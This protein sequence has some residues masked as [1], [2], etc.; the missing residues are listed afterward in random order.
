MK[1]AERRTKWVGRTS[2]RPRGRRPLVHGLLAALLMMCIVSLIGALVPSGT[3]AAGAIG[4]QDQSW[5]GT[6]TPTGTKRSE[7][8]LWWNDGLWWANMWSTGSRQFHIFRF[9]QATQS[10]SDTGVV[11]DRRSYTHADV[12][13]DGTHLYVASHQYVGESQPA[14]AGYPSYLYRFSYNAATKTYSL[15]SGFP[16]LINNLKTETLVIDKDS[17][18]TLWATWQQDNRIYVT[19]SV[20]GDTTWATPFALPSAGSNVTVD[21]NSAVIAF[22]GNKIGIM[23]SNQTTQADGMYFAVHV[24]GQP[25]TSWEPSRTAI[26]GAGTADDH[27]NLKTDGSGRVYAA[28]KTSFTQ[29]GAPLVM[30]L[31]RD[32]A[33]G[34]WSSYTV[35]RVSDCPTRALVVIDEQNRVLHVFYTAPAPPAYSCSNVGGAIYEKTSSL[36]AISFPTGYG[37]PVILDADSAY[38]NDVSSTKQ[39]VTAATGLLVLAVNGQLQYYWHAYEMLPGTQAPVADFIGNPTSGNAP[40]VVSFTDA[41]TGNPT[42]WSWSFG[43]GGTSTV[44]NPSHTFAAAGTYTVSLTASNAA[45]SSTMTKSGYITVT[46]SGNLTTTFLPVAD[47]DVSS[48][49]PNLNYATRTDLRVRTSTDQTVANYRSYLKFTVAGVAGTVTSAKLRLYVTDPSAD[50]GGIYS[51]VNSWTETG[52]TLRDSEHEFESRHVQQSRGRASAGTGRHG[53]ILTITCLNADEV[54]RSLAR[55]TGGSS[56][57]HRLHRFAANHLLR[58]FDSRRLRGSGTDFQRERPAILEANGIVEDAGGVLPGSYFRSFWRP[59]FRRALL[60]SLSHGPATARDGAERA[61][62]SAE[63]PQHGRLQPHRR[64]Q[65]G[66]SRG[67]PSIASARVLLPETRSSQQHVQDDVRRRGR[68]ANAFLALLREAQPAVCQRSNLERDRAGRKAA[69]DVCRKGPSRISRFGDQSHQRRPRRTAIDARQTTHRCET[70]DRHHGRSVLW[71][72]P[73]SRRPPRRERRLP[74]LVGRARPGN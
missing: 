57:C 50:G 59:L 38:L 32:P 56:F 65:L 25:D 18:E 49:Y 52:I 12:R 58:F 72:S 33:S 51:I 48:A 39:N 68:P 10:W 26:Q 14:V 46:S 42:A 60:R 3:A 40:L 66:P 19:H 74:N 70:A 13:W 30:L 45:G 2:G 6:G 36:D 23:W 55:H 37:T 8:V 69:L 22:G 21:D 9:D 54:A 4:Y 73:V 47:A 35:A 67:R 53:D 28:V 43:D 31:T 16:A 71:W 63:R 44:Q 7:S 62:D 20:G 34:D 61:R 11:V 1:K 17:T 29:S 27:M 41:S 15:D 24:D 64:H 5:A